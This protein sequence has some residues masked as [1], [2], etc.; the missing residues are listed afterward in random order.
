MTGRGVPFRHIPPMRSSLAP[1]LLAAL[2]AAAQPVTNIQVTDVLVEQVLRGQ[3][4]PA[5]Y[6]SSSPITDHGT[7]LCDMRHA[8]EADSL[9]ASLEVLERFHT[10]HS[11]SDTIS[12]VHG[13][14]AARRW[15]LSHFARSAQANEGRLLTGYLQFDWPN[16]SC[17]DA[18]G[19]R[20]VL[21]VLPGSDTSDHQLVLI[22]AH[23]DSRCAGDCDVDCPAPGMEDNGSGSALVLELARVMSRYTFRH[24]LVFMLTTGEEQGLVG[25]EAM[26]QWCAQEGIAIKAVQNNDIVGGVLCG[27]TSSAPSCAPPGSVDSLRVRL[28]AAG[29]VAAPHRTF[30]RTVRLMYQEKLQDQMAVPMAV[31]VMDR[32]DRDGRGGDHI[33][34]RA[35]GYRNVR[36]TSANEHGSAEV[37]S[38]WYT[39]HQHTSD[40][41]LGLD[42]D[43]DLAVDSFFVD[44]NYLQRNTLINGMAAALM[45]L[46]PPE[47]EFVV[48]DEPTGLRVSFTPAPGHMVYRVGVRRTN[49]GP[50]FDA[51]Y[52]TADTSY[53]VP[54]LTAGLGY[55]ISAAVVD[56]SGV[57][58]P[59]SREQVK[60]NDADTPPQ[61]VDDLPYGLS[62]WGIGV[63]EADAATSWTWL[64]PPTPDPFTEEALFTVN[65]PPGLAPRAEAYLLFRTADGRSLGRRPLRLVPGR[66]DVHYHHT[67]AAGVHTASLVIDGRVVATERFVVTR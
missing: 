12:D 42:T 63:P 62:C 3:Y 57:M 39:D 31:E 61:P 36:F 29:T 56:S 17:G 11:Y 15:A 16:G 59:F 34:F 38:A 33:P 60:G 9:R 26:A 4:D 49:S 51:V 2:P 22:E 46:G 32:E 18:F 8:L 40:D 44:F 14:G 7:M 21:A 6:A 23:L 67:G 52:R 48:H 66:T 45:A 20:N 35:Q 25:A 30:A 1:L 43:G 24:T 27:Q 5:Q 65:A 64:S 28:F 41:V 55:A 37:D 58:S 47:P 53:L 10:R 19:W 13:I 54:G 50:D